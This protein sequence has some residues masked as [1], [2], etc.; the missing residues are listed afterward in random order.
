MSNFSSKQVLGNELVVIDLDYDE[1]YREYV[2]ALRFNEIQVGIFERSDEDEYWVAHWHLRRLLAHAVHGETVEELVEKV[3]F[4]LEN[5]PAAFAR[6]L[7]Q[8]QERV[9]QDKAKMERHEKLQS[10]RSE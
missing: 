6:I 7:Q 8:R 1:N 9:D 4:V 5:D 10:R 2:A 3:A